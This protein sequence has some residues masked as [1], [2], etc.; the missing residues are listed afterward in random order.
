MNGKFCGVVGG[1]FP[2]AGE[3]MPAGVGADGLE[4]PVGGGPEPADSTPSSSEV[5]C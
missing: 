3:Q 1:A 2:S 4:G 5:R